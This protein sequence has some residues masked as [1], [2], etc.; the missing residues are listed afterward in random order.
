MPLAGSLSSSPD[1]IEEVY[2]INYEQFSLG[3]S[4]KVLPEAFT[5]MDRIRL[6]AWRFAS[7]GLRNKLN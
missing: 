7:T 1:G 4:L 3:Y 5:S 6:K 2:V